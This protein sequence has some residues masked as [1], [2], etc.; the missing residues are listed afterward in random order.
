MLYPLIPE[1]SA[2]SSS[3]KIQQG[4]MFSS[5][6]TAEQAKA[7]TLFLPTMLLQGG[8]ELGEGVSHLQSLCPA[9]LHLLPLL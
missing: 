4:K 1:V 9:L 3:S 8:L 6:L 2:S 7:P 5:C